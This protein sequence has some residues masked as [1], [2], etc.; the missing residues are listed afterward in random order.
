MKCPQIRH[1]KCRMKG[2]EARGMDITDNTAYDRVIHC[3]LC[4]TNKFI[5]VSMWKMALDKICVE[6][7]LGANF[8]KTTFAKLKSGLL[9]ASFRKDVLSCRK[10]AVQ[11]IFCY[12]HMESLGEK[13]KMFQ[14]CRGK[15][16]KRGWTENCVVSF[17]SGFP[18]KREACMA[19]ETVNEREEAVFIHVSQDTQEHTEKG[20]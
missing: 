8:G 18:W 12:P 5:V 14:Q 17:I 1:V 6:I 7:S 9:S 2:E 3:M 20:E 15:W 4:R 16:G 11:A 13:G 19:L 10:D